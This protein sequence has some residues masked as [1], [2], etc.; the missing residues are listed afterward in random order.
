MKLYTIGEAI[1]FDAQFIASGAAAT[2]LTV[3]AAVYDEANVAITP[4]PAVTEIGSTGVYTCSLSAVKND[5][6]GVY[7]AVFTTA[8]TADLD[9]VID[10]AQV[11]GKLFADEDALGSDLTLTLAGMLS[12]LRMRLND[13]DLGNYTT[14]ELQY[15]LNLALRETVVASKCHR[16]RIAVTLVDG[17]HTYDCG[18]VFEPISVHVSSV[19]LNKTDTKSLSMKVPGWDS[20]AKATPTDFIPYTG[21]FIRLYPTPAASGTAIV[22]GFA[23]PAPMENAGDVPVEVPAGYAWSSILDRAEAEARKMRITTPFNAV[24]FQ[25]L[26]ASWQNWC[27]KIRESCKGGE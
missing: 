27:Q 23:K 6:A 14:A 1:E 3:T 22:Y 26:M 13:L 5:A 8:G 11:R 17:T 9:T 24:L 12:G 18:D 21:G 4:A 19:P 15:C 2:G 16:K 25:E 7:K 10:F 20:T